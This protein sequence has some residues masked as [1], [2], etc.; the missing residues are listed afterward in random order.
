MV[1]EI[2]F[3]NYF[4]VIIKTNLAII[5]LSNL[6]ESQRLAATDKNDTLGENSVAISFVWGRNLPS[7]KVDSSLGFRSKQDTRAKLKPTQELVK[8]FHL[9][10]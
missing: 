8:Q 10:I 6:S 1:T 3:D 9:S 2:L 7:T 5:L 4:N